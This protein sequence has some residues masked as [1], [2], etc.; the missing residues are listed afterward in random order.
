MVGRLRQ[1]VGDQVDAPPAQRLQR[2][3]AV[4]VTVGDL[5]A[6]PGAID[7]NGGDPFDPA[8]RPG[9]S[10]H[11]TDAL[12]ALAELG[13]EQDTT[14]ELELLEVGFDRLEV[15]VAEFLLEHREQP[16]EPVGAELVGVLV[17]DGPQPLEAAKQHL[18]DAHRPRQDAVRRRVPGDPH[19]EIRSPLRLQRL[20]GDL[21]ELPHDGWLLEAVG[22]HLL[23]VDDRLGVGQAREDGLFGHVKQE[24]I[25]ARHGL[26]QGRKL[27]VLQQVR[28]VCRQ[29]ALQ[30]EVLVLVHEEGLHPVTRPALPL[31]LPF[32]MCRR[33]A[34]EVSPYW[35][36]I[37][38]A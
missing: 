4:V 11:V 19:P 37:A 28:F 32:P 34:S 6:V 24:P 1:R 8:L 30:V 22:K 23:A 35:L 9:S 27:Q 2:P 25:T 21:V 3:E 14:A 10:Q 18:Q 5:E 20:D 13:A 29:R 38:A 31:P 7:G 33:S 16:R 12:V 36:A 15:L 17:G 26:Q